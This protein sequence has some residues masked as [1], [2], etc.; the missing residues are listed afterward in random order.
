MTDVVYRGTRVSVLFIN[1]CG[2]V[3]WDRKAARY[4][5]REDERMKIFIHHK[6]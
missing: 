6:W 1:P 5:S 3:L 4:R 2:L